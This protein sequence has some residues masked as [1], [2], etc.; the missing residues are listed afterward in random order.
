MPKRHCEPPR[1]VS[2]LHDRRSFETDD[3]YKQYLAQRRKQQEIV[4]EIAAIV[5]VRSASASRLSGVRRLPP[6]Q[7]PKHPPPRQ[8]SSRRRGSVRQ[9]SSGWQHSS[10][11]RVHSLSA[12]RCAVSIRLTIKACDVCV[13]V[14]EKSD[15]CVPHESDC[16]FEI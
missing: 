11:A 5:R 1:E 8:S 2:P 4:N 10:S 13:C 9:R 15:V 12:R 16:M 7:P 3:E 6:K 14:Y